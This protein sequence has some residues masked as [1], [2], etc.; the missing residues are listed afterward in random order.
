MS[1][2]NVQLFNQGVFEDYHIF[3][4]GK[5]LGRMDAESYKAI[6]TSKSME[7]NYAFIYDT[8]AKAGEKSWWRADGTPY[9]KE[10][11]PK[12]YLIMSLLVT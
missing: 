1:L 2:H 9:P 6:C 10:Q 3:S 5:Y 11:I 8:K 12:D 7:Y 4:R